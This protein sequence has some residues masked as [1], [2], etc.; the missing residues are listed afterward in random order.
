MGG[1][2]PDQLPRSQDVDLVVSAFD[3]LLPAGLKKCLCQW[4]RV[5]EALHGSGCVAVKLMTW[6]LASSWLESTSTNLMDMQ[7]V[8]PTPALVVPFCLPLLDPFAVFSGILIWRSSQPPLLP[9]GPVALVALSLPVTCPVLHSIL[10]AGRNRLLQRTE[11][12]SSL[13]GRWK[14]GWNGKSK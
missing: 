13:R 14:L 12:I 11:N 1:S 3:F 9:S 5:E 7:F 6:I 2:A 8:C 10:K 4:N